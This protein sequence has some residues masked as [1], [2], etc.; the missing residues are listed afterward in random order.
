MNEVKAYAAF[1]PKKP[2]APYKINR[3][4]PRP[5]DVAIAIKY[6]GVCHSDVHQARDEWDFSP[7]FNDDQVHPG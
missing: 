2:L 7:K 4:D 6:C 5:N 3:R 1:D